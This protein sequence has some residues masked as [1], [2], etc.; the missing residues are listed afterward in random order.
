M[1]Q[2]G[3]EALTGAWL[4]GRKAERAED[5]CVRCHVHRLV[6]VLSLSEFQGLE[7]VAVPRSLRHSGP[8]VFIT[9]RVS[10]FEYC[11]CFGNVARTRFALSLPL[12]PFGALLL[13]A[14]CCEVLRSMASGALGGQVSLPLFCPVAFLPR[15]PVSVTGEL[16]VP[17]MS[18]DTDL[19][20]LRSLSTGVLRCS[21]RLGP[22][23]LGGLILLA[24]AFTTMKAGRCKDLQLPNLEGE[25]QGCSCQQGRRVSAS[26]LRLA[27]Q[28]S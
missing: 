9:Q 28:V 1:R 27:M 8:S 18:L 20:I 15:C 12:V 19:A 25:S 13:A 4:T 16:Q 14:F 10:R 17:G 2:A 7:R 5:D 11:F 3:R 21:S 24:I 26:G 6:H 22:L 23:P